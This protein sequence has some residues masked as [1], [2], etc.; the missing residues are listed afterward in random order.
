MSKS[1]QTAECIR[2]RGQQEIVLENTTTLQSILRILQT[3]PS[4]RLYS[5]FPPPPT[6]IST[7]ESFV[8]G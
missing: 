6:S 3:I 1:F 2:T 4:W 8:N 7:H 5:T